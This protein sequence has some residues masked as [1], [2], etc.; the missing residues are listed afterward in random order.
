MRYMLL[1]YGDETQ[2]GD[3]PPEQQAQEMQPWFDY[4]DWLRE[5]GW[6]LAGDALR[7]TEHATTVRVQ[8]GETLSTDRPFAETKEQLGGYYLLECENLDQAIEAAARC[9]GA[10]YGSI[11]IRPVVD[12]DMPEAGHEDH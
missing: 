8:S 7:E 3:V 10:A 9:P 5:R 12:F 11:E 2:G 6:M 4:T 1:I